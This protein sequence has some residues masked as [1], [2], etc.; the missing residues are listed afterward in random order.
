MKMKKIQFIRS[1]VKGGNVWQTKYYTI[2]LFPMVLSTIDVL[3]SRSS[4]EKTATKSS[5]QCFNI[6]TVCKKCYWHEIYPRN[7]PAQT[8]GTQNS[9]F[10]LRYFH[11][12]WHLDVSHLPLKCTFCHSPLS[13]SLASSTIHCIHFA[14]CSVANMNFR[15]RY[16]LKIQLFEFCS[17]YD[18]FQNTS[19]SWMRQYSPFWHVYNDVSFAFRR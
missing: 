18:G 7:G 6:A 9:T 10:N 12:R 17:F 13:P 3:S 11:I 19:G 1:H 2:L 8:E 16:N 15:S 5:G 4:P 14:V